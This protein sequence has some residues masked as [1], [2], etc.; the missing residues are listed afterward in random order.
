MLR[1]TAIIT[2]LGLVVPVLSTPNAGSTYSISPK[3]YPNLC[4]ASSN[5]ADGSSLVVTTCDNASSEIAWL[6]DGQTLSND[7][8]EMCIDITGGDDWSGNDA[9]VWSCYKGN[10][11]QMFA[12]NED[13]IEWNG[14]S[15][16]LDL[17]DG[18]GQAGTKIQIWSCGSS[19]PNQQW[20]FTETSVIDG[21]DST[22]SESSSE[23]RRLLSR[24]S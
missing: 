5:D 24:V 1:I 9:Q 21:C 16:C 6:Y 15:M 23:Y 14:K 13:L 18:K 12:I 7:A 10:Q 22:S 3:S 2:V 8:N 17:T 11:N 20:I 19:N 4:I